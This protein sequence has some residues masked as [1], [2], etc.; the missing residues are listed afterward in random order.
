MPASRY[1]VGIDLGT[2][3]CVVAYWDTGRSAGPNARIPVWDIPQVVAAGCVEGRPRLPSF[4]YLPSRHE[5]TPGGLALPWDHSRAE[6]VG[7]FARRRGS[8]VPGRLVSSAKS[9]LCHAGVDRN[10]PILPRGAPEDVASVSPVEASAR[11]LT[12][13]REAWH[14]VVAGSDESA[15]LERQEIILTIPASF[16]EVAREL[17]VEAARLAGLDRVTLIEEPQAAFYAWLSQ[18]EAEWEKLVKPGQLILVCDVGG[19]T[20]DFSLIR[21]EPRKSQI[22]FR[23]VAVGEH[24][25]LGGDNMDLALAAELEPVL[26]GQG[27]RLDVV[28]WSML[29]HACR[30]AKETLLS[31]AG[32]ESVSVSLPGRGSALVGG[33]L[34]CELRRERVVRCLLDGFF[35][36]TAR[37]EMPRRETR[38]ALQEFGLPYAQD[39]AV[40]R[41]LAAF[42]RTPGTTGGEGWRRP[43]LVLFNG[44]VFKAEIIQE[45][46]LKL[47]VSWFPEGRVPA[48]LRAEADDLDLAVARGATA[49]GRVRRGRGVRIGGGSARSFYIGLAVSAPEDVAGAPTAPLEALCVAPQGLEEGEEVEVAGRAFELRIKSPVAFP[50]YTSSTRPLD[51]LGEL[52]PVQPETLRPLPPV[53]TVLQAGRKSQEEQ[54]RVR[55]QS[56]LT[57]VGTLEIWCVSLDGS[58]RWRL[59]FDARLGAE[60]ELAEASRA[61]PVAEEELVDAARL[62]RGRARIRETFASHP[63]TAGR[64]QRPAGLMKNLE[65][66]LELGRQRWPPGALRGLWP[67]VLEAAGRRMADPAWEIRWLNLAGLVLRPGYGYPLDEWRIRHLWRI[68]DEGIA[69]PKD[70]QARIEWWI[71]W[72]RVAG[73]LSRAQQAELFRR[74]CPHLIPDGHGGQQGHG[75]R[76]PSQEDVERWRAV[77]SLERLSAREK[78]R[79]GDLLAARAGSG[80]VLPH[81][82]WVLGR[83]G[84]RM[85]FY[86][87]LDTVVSLEAAE[88]WIRKLLAHRSAAA[89][90]T[91]LALVE[92]ARMSGDRER[93]VGDGLRAEVLERLRADKAPARFIQLVREVVPLHEDEQALVF[94]ESLPPALRLVT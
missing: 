60:Q 55:L 88:S 46:I 86:G 64:E 91:C 3:N 13:L 48:L 74:M 77:A 33:T 68:F 51:R 15:L 83:L 29:R 49:Y 20:T 40:S 72:R 9:W 70:V 35:P 27:R 38:T 84:A 26:A 22:G 30:S 42:L 85:P 53:Q 61:G 6:V 39:P 41:H 31:P 23:R 7:E 4:L 2:T 62:E 80:R 25:L 54:V 52:I 10:A 44:G 89:A 75:T 58:R 24:L 94:G 11:Y 92:L 18:H 17:T 71:M 87:P 50:F 43:D 73:G 37:K 69:H 63:A 1:I 57:E 21:V 93:D 79:L 65:T 28:Q 47:L 82:I 5:L 12:H 8:E 59:R 67:A 78:R 66:V 36:L 45:R 32:P 90:G 16:D 76:K 19:G 14:A 34:R 56:V 81:E